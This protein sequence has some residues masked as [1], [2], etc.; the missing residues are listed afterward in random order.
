MGGALGRRGGEGRAYGWCSC[1]PFK[2]SPGPTPSTIG[3]LRLLHVQLANLGARR[4]D[5]QSTLEGLVAAQDG[6]EARL[7]DDAE[8]SETKTSSTVGDSSSGNSRGGP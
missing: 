6:E 3:G 2:G 8:R 4:D 1:A 5:L 7:L